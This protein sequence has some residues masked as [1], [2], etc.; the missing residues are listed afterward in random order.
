MI[1]MSPAVGS[2][3]AT[4]RASSNP[5][6]SNQRVTTFDRSRESFGGCHFVRGR[7]VVR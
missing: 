1:K 7:I 6:V 3:F 2:V 5:T 4:I